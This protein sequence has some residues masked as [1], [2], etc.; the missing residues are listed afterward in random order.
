VGH[1][2][3]CEPGDRAGQQV[4]DFPEFNEAIVTALAALADAVE[5][6]LPIIKNAEWQ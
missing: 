5:A 2:S 1:A 6:P 3:G 4:L